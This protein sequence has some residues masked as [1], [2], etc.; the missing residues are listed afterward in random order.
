MYK[1]WKKE[2]D[3]EKIN[4]TRRYWVHPILTG[5][6][7]HGEFHVLF[8]EL[9]NHDDE[10]YGYLRMTKRTF[11]KLLSFLNTKLEHQHTVMRDSISSAERLVVTLR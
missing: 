4:S 7:K 11:D 10:F 8:A 2:K 3:S 6:E 9:R 1:Q 5:R